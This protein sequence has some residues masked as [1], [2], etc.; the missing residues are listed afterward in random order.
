MAYS[1][2]IDNFLEEFEQGCRNIEKK[3]FK[4][5]QIITTYIRNR[6]QICILLNGEADLVR[7]D[8]NGNKTIVEHFTKNDVFGEALYVVVTNNELSVQAKRN[9]EV[10]FFKYD[11]IHQRCKSNC[12]FHQILV[13][14][15][16]TIILNK[17]TD[18]N[19]RIEILTKRSIR[20]KLRGYF[21]MLSTRNLNKT[22][23]I[24]FSLTDLADYLSVDRSAM[25]R[26]LKTLQDEGF[27]KKVGNKITLLY[28]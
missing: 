16:S 5:N 26:E 27:I 22:F 12:K 20:E 21:N 28:S 9:C 15:F 3:S 24:P 8:L 7:Y 4:K 18:L 10:L 6:N 19:T 11:I 1:F 17:A 23:Y 2:N 14:N 25:M 13:E